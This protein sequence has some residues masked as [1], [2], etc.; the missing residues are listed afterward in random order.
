MTHL[1]SSQF[2]MNEVSIN[3]RVLYKL[4]IKPTRLFQSLVVCGLECS[5]IRSINIALF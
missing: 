4:I 5:M 1:T 3:F 2:D